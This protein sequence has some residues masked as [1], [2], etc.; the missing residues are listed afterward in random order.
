MEK[1]AANWLLKFTSG[2]LYSIRLCH[3]CYTNA[4]E[5][6]TEWIYMVCKQRHPVVWAKLD[7]YPWWPAK[8][9][10]TNER[11]ETVDVHFFGEN[12]HATIFK[13]YCINYTEECPSQYFG[14]HKDK[15]DEAQEVNKYFQF[16][17]S[18]NDFLCPHLFVTLRRQPNCTSIN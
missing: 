17:F 8:L 1:K 18:S 2:E 11:D 9:M 6:P 14:G 4:N 15:W 5:H 10:A 7:T 13:N 16:C 12:N 3:E